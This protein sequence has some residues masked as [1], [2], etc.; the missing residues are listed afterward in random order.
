MNHNLLLAITM[1][2]SHSREN[3]IGQKFAHDPKCKM[4]H[5]QF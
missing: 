5:Q 4:S 1:L 3:L 2:H